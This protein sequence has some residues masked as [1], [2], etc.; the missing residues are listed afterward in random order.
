MSLG[1][2]LA[3]FSF[4]FQNRGTYIAQSNLLIFFT[5]KQTFEGRCYVYIFMD[6]CIKIILQNLLFL[7]EKNFV[8]E[9]KVCTP[10][11]TF[12]LRCF[13]FQ[14]CPSL[15][16]TLCS[17]SPLPPLKR[18]ILS[19]CKQ[20]LHAKLQLYVATPLHKT[21]FPIKLL[22]VLRCTGICCLGEE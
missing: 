10:S 1:I 19:W 13:I 15:P 21:V 9:Q 11:L 7:M 20:L 16:C 14:V 4:F 17:L 8:F 22:K 18:Q 2:C 12:Q 3:G 6:Y 5:Y